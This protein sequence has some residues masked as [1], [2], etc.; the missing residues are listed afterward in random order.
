MKS[1][2]ILLTVHNRKEKTLECLR[3]VYSQLPVDNWDIQVYLTDDGCTDG[4]PKAIREL[5]PE[6]HIIP[7]DGNLYWNRGMIAAWKAAAADKDFDAYLWLNDDTMLSESAIHT[8]L[9]GLMQKPDSIIVGTTK[10]SISDK[11]TYGGYNESGIIKPN[12][13][14][15]LCSSFN[16]NVVLVPRPVF[17]KI[18]I[19]DKAYSHSLGD[20]DYGMTAAENGIKSFVAPDYIGTCENNPLPPKWQ[21]KGISLKER[22]NNLFSPLGYTNPPEYY[23]YKRKHWGHTHAILA[24]CSI[25]IHFVAPSLWRKLKGR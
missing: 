13:E 11:T 24:M 1:L 15:Q 18:G 22:W 16:G 23:H 10:S 14:L 5:F 6:V 3:R 21:R 17:K 7:G 2:A 20:I 25:A 12:G 4:T 8:V 9:N 19:L